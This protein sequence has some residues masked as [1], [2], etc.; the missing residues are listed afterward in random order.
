MSQRF[1][2]V[3]EAEADFRTAT[4]LAD[5]VL[6]ES[7]DWLDEDMIGDQR[8]WVDREA[9]GQRLTWKTIPDLASEVRI[10]PHGR[11]GG[12]PGKADAF[13][14]RRAILYL[15]AIAPDL[16]AILLIRDQDDQPERREGLEQAR[17]HVR[18][19]A[20]I[21]IGLAVV[22][23]ESWVLSGFDPQG[24]KEAALLD[25][26]RQALKFDPRHRSHELTAHKA[27]GAPRS[28]KRVLRTLCRDD[29][30]RERHCWT[31]TSLEVLMER[32]SE[33]GLAAYLHEI[34]DRLA[35][36]IGHVPD[37]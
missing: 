29:R 11:F 21:V 12:E 19:E 25:L 37:V 31:T 4:E 35:P 32:G 17:R 30:D 2:V 18:S 15:R 34:W 9:G 27:D 36:L 16:K 5:R 10:R 8:E 7:I 26:E 22:E 20:V 14:A 6:T 23:R 28:P 24:D 1:A 3:H 13:A 33:N